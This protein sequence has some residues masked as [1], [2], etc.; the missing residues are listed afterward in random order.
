M[1]DTTLRRIINKTDLCKFCLTTECRQI[2]KSSKQF[3]QCNKK[4][5]RLDNPELL[6]N[7]EGETNK[8]EV[9]KNK[10]QQNQQNLNNQTQKKETEIKPEERFE[11]ISD[12]DQT[13][14]EAFIQSMEERGFPTLTGKII[15]LSNN[16]TTIKKKL[17]SKTGNITLSRN[18]GHRASNTIIKREITK[19]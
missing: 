6:N 4:L 3:V 19:K 10:L 7:L 16:S 11:E 2:Q 15:K 1:G 17:Y 18:H 13:N 12:D 8:T 5:N 14:M 9:L